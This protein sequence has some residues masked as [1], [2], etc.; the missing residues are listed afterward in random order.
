MVASCPRCKADVS[1]GTSKDSVIDL[2]ENGKL[3]V[4]CPRCDFAWILPSDEQKS[5]AENLRKQP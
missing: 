1:L 5:I 2:A 4:M 3:R